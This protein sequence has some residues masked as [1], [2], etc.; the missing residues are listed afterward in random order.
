MMW[1]QRAGQAIRRR[2][3]KKRQKLAKGPGF[4]QKTGVFQDF[5]SEIANPFLYAYIPAH[6]PDH[7]GWKR[8]A[9]ASDF[10]LHGAET[11]L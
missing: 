6:S 10:E 11:S 3:F 9:G 5:C 4:R 2:C 7:G 8:N 1:R